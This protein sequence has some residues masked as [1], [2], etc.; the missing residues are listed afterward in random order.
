MNQNTW[1]EQMEKILLKF[2]RSVNV[3]KDIKSRRDFKYHQV[4]PIHS[5]IE[6]YLVKEDR[7]LTKNHQAMYY[8]SWVWTSLILSSFFS[9]P[10]LRKNWYKALE[11]L[12]ISY[13][14]GQWLIAQEDSQ[15]TLAMKVLKE[16]PFW[17]F[18]I[19]SIYL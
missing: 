5:E 19:P 8:Q 15:I 3:L 1:N 17:S 10:W 9:I 4:Q 13:H 11:E 2:P 7:Y 12:W 6:S 18:F 14:L 16:K